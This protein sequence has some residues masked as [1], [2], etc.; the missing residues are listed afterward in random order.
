V[1]IA[2]PRINRGTRRSSIVEVTEVEPVRE[3]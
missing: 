1:N 3:N 2:L